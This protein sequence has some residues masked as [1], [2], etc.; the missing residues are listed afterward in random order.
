MRRTLSHVIRKDLSLHLCLEEV[1]SV[2]CENGADPRKFDSSNYTDRKSRALQRF[3]L[4]RIRESYY[5]FEVH[6]KLFLQNLTS[7]VKKNEK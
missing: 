1:D 6:K 2:K 5:S 3:N 4:V 7:P